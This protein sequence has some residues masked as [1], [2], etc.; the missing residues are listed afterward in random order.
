VPA[1]LTY[2]PGVWRMPVSDGGSM[3]P[4][5]GFVVS[6][7]KVRG[8]YHV[9]ARRSGRVAEGGALLRR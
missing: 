1:P 4:E 3:N 5:A 6:G 9:A 2:P 7:L 8:R